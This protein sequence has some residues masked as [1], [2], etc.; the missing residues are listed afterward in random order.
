VEKHRKLLSGMQ[1]INLIYLLDKIGKIV[2][3]FINGELNMNKLT[4]GMNGIFLFNKTIAVI[5]RVANPETF[6][7]T[8]G[9]VS[10][11]SITA[12]YL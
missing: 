2:Y 1:R 8:R 5:L 10:P 11:S 6:S 12:F 9:T 4:L 3:N 7:P